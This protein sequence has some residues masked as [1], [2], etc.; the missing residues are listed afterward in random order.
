V[1]DAFYQRD[2]ESIFVPHVPVVHRDEDY[3]QLNFETLLQMQQGHFW[4]GGRSRFL[5]AAVRRTLGLSKHSLRRNLS[6]VDLGGGCGGWISYLSQ[7]IIGVFDELA[8]ADSS[9]KALELAGPVLP[10][11]T[12]RYHIDVLN[13]HWRERWDVIFFLDV[14]ENISQDELAMQEIS[15][16]LKPGGF[17]FLTTTAL[18]RFRTWNDEAVHIYRRYS[19]RDLQQLAS[20]TGLDLLQARYFMF[21]LSPLLL[22]SRLK[23]PPLD[24]MS[25]SEIAE[26]LART[27]R[28][29][30]PVINGICTAVFAAETPLGLLLPFPWGTSILGIYR[31]PY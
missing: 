31:K 1:I 25:R 2:T 4:Y 8:L 22:A 12:P 29:P 24:S 19:R 13:L 5:L 6:A 18:E 3:D 7:K 10:A 27:H 20:K 23:R 30:G 9:R 26:L 17:L 15:K 14:L 28:I 21:F 11:G 16:A